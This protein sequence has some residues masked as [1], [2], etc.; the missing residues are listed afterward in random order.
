MDNASVGAAPQHVSTAPHSAAMPR[1]AIHLPWAKRCHAP[2]MGNALPCGFRRPR[3]GAVRRS[4]SAHPR[5]GAAVVQL[6]STR[7]SVDAGTLQV[8]IRPP[9]V[10]ERHSK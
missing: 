8:S 1:L 9:R 5:D 2:A 7:A 6:T 10:K 4:T 3:S